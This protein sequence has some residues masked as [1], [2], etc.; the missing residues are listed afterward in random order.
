MKLNTNQ[1]SFSSY[2]R[3]N[4][5]YDEIFSENNEVKEVYKT[6][7]NLYSE[8]TV[9]DF[10]RLNEKAKASFFNQGIT[11]QVYGEHE[12]KEKIFPFD[13][14][15]RIIDHK[16]WSHIEKGVL[17]R[18]KA[19]NHFLWDIYHDKK[20]LKQGIVPLDL[21]NS[22]AN[23]LDQMQGLNPPGGSRRLCTVSATKQRRTRYC[24]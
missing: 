14:F 6:L 1:P 20:I 11:F 9:H 8:H 19:L 21:I 7:L 3:D 23:Y 13:L 10:A 4:H 16:E 2:R 12:T 5:F 17:Q 18:S 15:P 22:S 24:D